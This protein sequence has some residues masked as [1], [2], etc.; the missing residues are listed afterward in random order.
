MEGP[1]H[2]IGWRHLEV[3]KATIQLHC[4]IHIKETL[5]NPSW[6]SVA[7]VGEDVALSTNFEVCDFVVGRE[8][9]VVRVVTSP[10]PLH[11]RHLKLVY[12]L[13]LSFLFKLT[14]QT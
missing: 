7:D 5:T 2:S 9:L 3:F 8:D 13:L 4:A 1:L 10:W 14:N 12:T 11:G 6:K